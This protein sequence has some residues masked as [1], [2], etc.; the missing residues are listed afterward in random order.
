MAP[1]ALEVVRTGA[2][3]LEPSRIIVPMTA[4]RVIGTV[5]LAVDGREF[6]TQDVLVAE[7]FGLRA[8]AAVENARLYRAA[9]RIARTLQTSLL[10]PGL[11]DVP[12]A[13]LGGGVSPRRAGTGGRWGFLRR[14]L[15][16]EVSGSS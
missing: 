9:T 2:A 1:E 6:D 13:Q 11:P 7:D 3:W 4:G 10:P 15:T 5:T 8:G 12:G 16:G 14:L